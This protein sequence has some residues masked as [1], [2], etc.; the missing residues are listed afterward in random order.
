MLNSV[1]RGRKLLNCTYKPGNYY[2]HNIILLENSTF[3]DVFVVS[4]DRR[5][6]WNGKLDCY[7]KEEK[8]RQKEE[9]KMV[10]VPKLLREDR[11]FVFGFL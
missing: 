5:M 9:K 1:N 3:F 10:Y 2:H 4:A 8:K 6:A 7:L 11:R